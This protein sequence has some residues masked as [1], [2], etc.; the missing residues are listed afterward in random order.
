[1]DI[2]DIAGEMSSIRADFCKYL[3]FIGIYLIL[4][5]Q[6]GGCSR[7][8]FSLFSV[9]IITY[10]DKPFLHIAILNKI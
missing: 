9:S 6:G 4:C 7:R 5:T 1:M 2:D 10:L 3:K 8:P